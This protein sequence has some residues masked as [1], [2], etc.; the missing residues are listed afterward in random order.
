V[1]AAA[2]DDF[3][4]ELLN[5]LEEIPVRVPAPARPASAEGAREPAK[6]TGREVDSGLYK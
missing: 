5:S 6:E 3:C 2:I 4:R 1:F